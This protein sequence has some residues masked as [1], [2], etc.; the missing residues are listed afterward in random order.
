MALFAGERWKRVV[1]WLAIAGYGLIVSGLPLPFGPTASVTASRSLPGKD[2]SRP[3]PCMDS[4]CGCATAEQ[5][6]ANC[7]CHSPGERLAWAR[8]HGV[9]PAVLAALEHRAKPSDRA[10]SKN[11]CSSAPRDCGERESPRYE[12]EDVCSDYRFSATDPGQGH[13]G[14]GRNEPDASGGRVISLRAMLACHG[15]AAGWTAAVVSLPPPP[16]MLL[17]LHLACLGRIV[18][19]DERPRFVVSLLDPPPPRA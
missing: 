16:P 11:C 7:C 13:S 8:S 2:R 1:T 5:C 10:V 12:G 9:E 19:S 15:I 3:F 6:F 17:S 4:P 14:G 18:T